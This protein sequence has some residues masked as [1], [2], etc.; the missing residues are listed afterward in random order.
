MKFKKEDIDDPEIVNKRLADA[1][2]DKC[3]EKIH[4]RLKESE[5]KY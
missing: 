4:K 3:T 5:I 1:V 2:A